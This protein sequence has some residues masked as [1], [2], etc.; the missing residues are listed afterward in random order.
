MR[1]NK[2]NAD[3]IVKRSIEMQKEVYATT[4]TQLQATAKEMGIVTVCLTQKQAA[5]VTGLCVQKLREMGLTQNIT[6]ERIARELS[7]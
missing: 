7:A 1:Y 4:L 2:I 5:A 6:L 3:E